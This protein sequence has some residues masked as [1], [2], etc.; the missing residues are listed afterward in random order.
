VIRIGIFAKTF[1]GNNPRAVLTQV[2]GAGFKTTQYNMSCSGLASMPEAI[3]ARICAA[4]RMA[5]AETGVAIAALS[6]TFNMI[7]PDPAVRSLG[8]RRLAVLARA[9][10]AIGSDLITLCTGTRDPEDQWR[11]HPENGTPEAWGDLR[12]SMQK[13]VRIAEEADIFLGIE[14]EQANVVSSAE[15]AR[16]LIDEMASPRLKIVFDAANL[17]ESASPAGRREI[18]SRGLDLLADRIVMAHAKDRLPNRS[19]ATAGTGVLDYPHYVAELHRIGFDGALVAHGL[20]ATEASGV[21]RF[22][23]RTIAAAAT[24]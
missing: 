9:A 3:D 14:P 22:L 13:A 18:V 15:A 23:L 5:A 17:F 16:R 24:A 12:V 21:A 11:A 7:H 4:I 19:F 2:A 1:K 20:E 6:G 10:P 8:F